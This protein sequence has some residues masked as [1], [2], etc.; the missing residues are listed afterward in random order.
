MLEL[1]RITRL[2]HVVSCPNIFILFNQ[3]NWQGG[4]LRVMKNYH[5]VV[6]LAVWVFFP[7]FLFTLRS[8]L[9]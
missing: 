1:N 3:E 7:K 6:F 9:R 4:V 2:S 8:A 5:F